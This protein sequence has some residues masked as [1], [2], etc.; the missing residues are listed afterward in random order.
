MR[1]ADV[2]VHLRDGQDGSIVADVD[3]RFRMAASGVE[4]GGGRPLYVRFP[5]FFADEPTPVETRFSVAIDGREP[6]DLAA[7]SWF[8]IDETGHKRRQQGYTW[9]VGFEDRPSR[10]IDVR[11][12]L[13][14]PEKDGR[15][16]FIY[17]LRSGAKWNG[18]IGRELVRVFADRTLRMDVVGPI[19]VKPVTRTVRELAWEIN[20][21]KPDED[22]RLAVARSVAE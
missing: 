10:Q 2:E 17:F 15:A 4:R 14:L 20:N 11:Y 3:C 21:A 22:I 19:A 13:I 12:S 6:Q 9:E 8:D 18:P 16:Q 1:S 7:D 5:L